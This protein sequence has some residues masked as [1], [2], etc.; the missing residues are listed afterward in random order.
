M[1]VQG[2][3][4]KVV[5]KGEGRMRRNN[6]KGVLKNKRKLGNYLCLGEPKKGA[7][8]RKCLKM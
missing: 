1:G 6:M 3:G 7:K 5:T 4:K 8:K 2:K